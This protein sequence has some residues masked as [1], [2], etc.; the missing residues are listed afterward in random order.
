MIAARKKDRFKNSY[1]SQDAGHSEERGDVASNWSSEQVMNLFPLSKY[2]AE[3]PEEELLIED[4]LTYEM[5]LAQ[6]EKDEERISEYLETLDDAAQA[7][8]S[9]YVGQ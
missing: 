3:Q 2:I 5:L 4:I 7:S 8:K 6:R 9:M 1:V